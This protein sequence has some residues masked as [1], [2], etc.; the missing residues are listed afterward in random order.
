MEKKK[1]YSNKSENAPLRKSDHTQ[2]QERP[3]EKVFPHPETRGKFETF[4]FIPI[5]A[6]QGF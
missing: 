1:N 2:D 3:R 5:C 4:V 6:Q